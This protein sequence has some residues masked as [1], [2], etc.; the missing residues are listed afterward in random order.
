MLGV[1]FNATI[2]A[3]AFKK[4]A[5][6]LE[7]PVTT[8]W[9]LLHPIISVLALA[10]R[11]LSLSRLLVLHVLLQLLL[12]AVVMSVAAIIGLHRIVVR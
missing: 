12:L 9:F 4:S 8:L 7:L 11:Y 3:P 2:E 6:S 1:V 5:L 10:T